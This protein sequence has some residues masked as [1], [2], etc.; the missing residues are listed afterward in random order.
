MEVEGRYT[1][2]WKKKQWKDPQ[3]ALPETW[4]LIYAYL[5]AAIQPDEAFWPS[6]QPPPPLRPGVFRWND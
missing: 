2:R 5:Q 1:R 3:F 4:L 6:I